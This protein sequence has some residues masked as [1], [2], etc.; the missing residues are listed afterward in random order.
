MG[1]SFSINIGNENACKILRSNINTAFSDIASVSEPSIFCEKKYDD[2][3]VTIENYY[4]DQCTFQTDTENAPNIDGKIGDFKQGKTG[5]CYIL[6]AVKALSLTEE[7]A[8]ILSD[9]ISNVGHGVVV[10]FKGG[11]S[12]INDV[13]ISN[14]EIA[15]AKEKSKN[16]QDNS[17]SS[18]DDDVTII[19]LAIQKYRLA[20]VA[21]DRRNNNI[22]NDK[23]SEKV[24]KQNIIKGGSAAEIMELLTKRQAS[25]ENVFDNNGKGILDNTE[26]TLSESEL[27]S[28]FSS[29]IANMLNEGPVVLSVKK[30]E[31]IDEPF[32]V[33]DR[34]NSKKNNQSDKM[35]QVGKVSL[36][37]SHAYTVSGID[38]NTITLK[39]PHDSSKDVKIPLNDFIKYANTH[40]NAFKVQFADLNGSTI[41][42]K[43]MKLCSEDY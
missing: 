7:G 27:N 29:R 13:F 4:T 11:K 24:S 37:K 39:N 28:R 5:D 26:K 33:D 6:S 9:S 20:E 25:S 12:E 22:C 8:K 1:D 3:T 21:Y 2:C 31:N 36:Y 41:R 42:P 23:L 10:N 14:E 30:Q 17:L 18:G 40:P 43:Q 32:V 15:T 34:R 16:K 38:N 35:I 19:E